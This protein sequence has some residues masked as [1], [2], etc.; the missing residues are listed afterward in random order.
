MLSVCSIFS[1]SWGEHAGS[2]LSGVG[3]IWGEQLRR[4]GPSL[5]IGQVSISPS[6]DAV[7][8]G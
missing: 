4:T 2:A 6:R 7:P 3:P 5:K 1:T 8:S